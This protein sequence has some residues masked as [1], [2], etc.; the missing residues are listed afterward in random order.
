M[1]DYFLEQFKKEKCVALASVG[2]WK[3]AQEHG[4]HLRQLGHDKLHRSMQR[5]RDN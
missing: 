1:L 5:I 3:R 4:Q 2:L